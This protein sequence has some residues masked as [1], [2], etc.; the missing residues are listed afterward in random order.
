MV[1]CA[2][3]MV[4]VTLFFGLRPKDFSFSNQVTWIKDQS[5]IRFEKSGMA[6]SKPI[7][8]STATALS[9]PDGFSIEM[10]LK[11]QSFNDEGF[12]FILSIHDGKDR[13][14][15]LIGQWRSWII[16]MN[17][18]D[19]SN[20]K[21]IPRIVVDPISPT[22]TKIFLSITTGKEGTKA[23]V[24]GQLVKTNSD[25]ILKFPKRG[26]SRLVIGNSVYGKHSWKGEIY[27]LGFYGYPLTNQ[28]ATTHFDRWLK[29]RN[30]SFAK[31]EKPFMLYL[32]NEE[33]GTRAI[34]QGIANLSLEIP[35]KVNVLEK[36][37]LSPPWR[38]LKLNGHF[39]QDAVI[40]FIGFMPLGFIMIATL[41]QFHRSFG[42]RVVLITVALCFLV[43][44][45]IEIIQAWIPSR[46]SQMSDLMLNTCGAWVGAM[47]YKMVADENN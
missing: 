43:S 35:A 9:G 24:N 14:Q 26:E 42:K 2:T 41:I 18:D 45:A 10:A 16:I 21:K 38:D 30:F 1:G 34:D 47:I 4:F 8:D 44:L 36:R 23:Y 5:G 12:N 19:Y 46:S 13:D 3:I 6:Y 28:D 37:I 11:P 17:G 20:K 25:L 7:I 22:P 27:G 40:N 15:L 32:L 33:K 39:L 29:E 31:K